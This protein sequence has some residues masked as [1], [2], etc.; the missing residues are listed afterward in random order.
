MAFVFGMAAPP[1]R[2]AAATVA[3]D[4]STTTNKAKGDELE[5]VVVTGS[6]IPQVRAETSQPVTVITAEDIQAK[7]FSTVAEALQRSSFATG[8]GCVISRHSEPRRSSFKHWLVR[9]SYGSGRL[10]CRQEADW[11]SARF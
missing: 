5:E 11:P 2:A 3:A 4:S 1:V 10:D 7:G 8:R 6:L 9:G